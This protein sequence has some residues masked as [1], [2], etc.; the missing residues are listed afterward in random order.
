MLP[1]AT[2]MGRGPRY[3]S[4]VEVRLGVCRERGADQ[5][6]KMFVDLPREKRA[7]RVHPPR[8]HEHESSDE[9]FSEQIR[10]RTSHARPPAL[11]RRACDHLD[12]C[13]PLARAS[14]WSSNV[15]SEENWSRRPDLN[16]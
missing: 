11:S 12:Q 5:R 8:Q 2:S 14:M 3:G 9:V 15:L 7:P 4:Q 6:K 16:G 1:G 10:R 13:S